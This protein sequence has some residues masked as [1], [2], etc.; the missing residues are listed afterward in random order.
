MTVNGY[1]WIGVAGFLLTFCGF[2]AL[3]YYAEHHR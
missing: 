3:V 2:C 1:Q